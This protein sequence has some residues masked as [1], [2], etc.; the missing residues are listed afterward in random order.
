MKIK[1][2]MLATEVPELDFLFKQHRTFLCSPKLDGIRAMIVEGKLVSRNFKAI[3]NVFIRTE[4]EKMNLPEGIDGEITVG[5]TFNSSTS[6]VM[7]FEEEPRFTFHVFDVCSNDPFNV[8]YENLQKFCEKCQD[9]R[10]VIVPHIKIDST[11][12]LL[13]YEEKCLKEGFEG[14][15]LRKLT[16]PYKFGRSSQNEAYLLKLKRFY[17]SEAKI[18]AIEELMSNQNDAELDAFGRTKRSQKQENLIPAGTMGSLIV[19]DIESGIE[20]KIGTGF[21]QEMRD[22]FYENSQQLIGKIV[23]YKSQESGK[24]EKPRFPVFLGFR[25]INDLS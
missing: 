18:I 23:K 4:I 15:M 3:P 5:E 8:R 16:G 13:K 14:V 12:E 24:V 1:K 17:D 2:P 11:E 19:Q 9:P 10:I 7:R 21:T 6:A 20:F 22:W 25:D